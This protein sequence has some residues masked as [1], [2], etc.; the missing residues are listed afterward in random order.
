MHNAFRTFSLAL[1][2]LGRLSTAQ[3][4]T[5]PRKAAKAARLQGKLTIDGRLDEAAWKAA[6]E[7]TRF[8]KTGLRERRIIP[9]DTQTSFRVLYDDATLYFGIRCR[10]PKMGEL[11]VKAADKHDAA[12]WSDDDVELFIDPVGDRN[13]YYQFAVNSR[14]TQV[15]LYMIERGNTGKRYSAV[16][17]A[18]TYRG[19]D[20]W[21]VEIALP[22]AALFQRPSES[23]CENWVFSISR[24]R[25]PAPRYYSQFS[26]GNKYHDI[27]SFGTL[28]PIE[29]DRSR[30]N[31]SAESPA[32]QLTPAR[33]GF[34][35]AASF[36]LENRGAEPFA[37][38]ANMTI[39]TEKPVTARIRV[40]L[41]P[42]S[43]SSLAFPK[44]RMA[45]QG[46]FPVLLEV[47]DDD[48][49]P[50]LAARF[51]ER[52]DYHPLTV[53]LTRPNYRDAI[54]PTQQIKTVVGTL[55][56]NLALDDIRGKTARVSLSG[57]LTQPR[58]FTAR[59]DGAETAFEIDVDHLPMGD[60]TLR[61]EIVAETGKGGKASTTVLAEQ[62][63]LFRKLPPAAVEARIDREGNLLIDGVPVFIR[64]W[65]GSMNYVRSTAA[66]P[67][68]QLPRTTNFIMGSTRDTCA[69][70]G[71]Y[72]L[73]GITRLIDETKA[74]LDQPIDGELKA[75]LRAVVAE[76][77]DNPAI[78]GY[79]ISDEPECRGLSPYYLKTLYEF[80]RKLDPYRFCMI[81]SRAP[82][83]YME[84]CDVMCPHPYLSPQQYDDGTRAFANYLLG[85]RNVM[86]KAV[87]A[88]DGSKAVWCMPQTFSY[89]GP[90]SRHPNFLE[91]RWFTYTALANG[92][93]G[94]VPFIFNGY[95]NHL[96][97]RISMDAVFEELALLAPAW[98]HPGTATAIRSSN[99]DVD[100]IAK[101]YRPEKAPRSHIF[102]VAA[103]Q[104]YKPNRSVFEVP[105]LKAAKNS[106]LIVLRE[107]RV[108]PMRNGRF[109][110]SFGRLGV[111]V[112]TTLEA[113]PYLRSLDRI[114]AKIKRLLARSADKGNLLAQPG[115]RW[116]VEGTKGIFG[117]NDALVDG[118]LAAGGWLPVYGDRSKC[119]IHFENPLAFSRV[120]LYTPSIR[121]AQL[122]ARIDGRWRL[123]HTWTDQLVQRLE[124]TGRTITATGIRVT[125]TKRR[126][127]WTGE[128]LPEIT[129]LEL[130]K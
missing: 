2:I 122:H 38:A 104:S 15:D 51:D 81:V 99:P 106:R 56:A 47:V 21:S 111:H 31:L 120:V 54:Y 43:A 45:A 7:H 27:D 3:L 29:I 10:E 67:E 41:P 76:V 49:T 82:D 39:L 96:E 127:T 16:W 130:Y 87:A 117:R 70:T 126:K 63:R 25:T 48:G 9:E 36:Q 12:M 50:T 32:F 14:G 75:K 58:V 112:Y 85:I 40:T 26:P 91:S 94:I 121:D 64:G 33:D 110:D 119:E 108:V 62:E 6:P 128:A 53:R 13:E 115:V 77:R 37:G 19:D 114:R 101:S 30:F 34:D 57:P 28:G 98:K 100:A 109:Q 69:E 59:I 80:L 88:N 73:R 105:A 4:P 93:K 66:F 17:Q 78:I 60:Y 90:T 72:T 89:G 24:T 79:Y 1:L 55:R 46:K 103:N 71:L 129:E 8:E 22:F 84:A 5:G 61:A 107:N 35:V 44:V 20:F 42:R 95:W 124:Y 86:R 23:W 97:N 113:L 18:E 92:A 125:P 102:I 123:L 116:R 11:T 74:K 68:G 118:E 65:Y 52:L 83:T